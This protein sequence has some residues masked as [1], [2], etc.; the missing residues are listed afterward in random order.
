MRRC[1]VFRWLAFSLTLGLPLA[2]QAPAQTVSAVPAFDVLSVKPDDAGSPGGGISLRADGI[3]VEH[4][5]FRFLL[6]AAFG[7]D[8]AE[9]HIVNM[10]TWASDQF[11]IVGKVAD[12]DLPK[13]HGLDREHYIEMRSKLLQ[14]VLAQR[15]GLKTHTEVREGRV[16]A[17][18]AAKG[19]PKIKPSGEKPPAEYVSP[20]GQHVQLGTQATI[21]TIAGH[22]APLAMLVRALNSAGQLDRVV[23]DQTG[24][25]GNF[26]YA[27]NWA[28]DQATGADPVDTNLPPLFTAIQ[29]QLGLRLEPSTGPISTFVIDH[30]EKPSGN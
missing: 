13:L 29:E 28:P 22:V 20:T 26:D 5:P 25:A 1:N 30:V 16:Y 23:V 24:L 15:F 9:D 10:P 14:A 17:L 3:Y 7:H 21:G 8:F 18:V 6:I 11:D 2:S 12:A 19:G 27:L 4:A